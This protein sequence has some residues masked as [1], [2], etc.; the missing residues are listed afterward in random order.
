MEA[1]YG[2]FTKIIFW[3]D[4]YG[5]RST[6][7][8][9]S[10]TK[11]T[12]LNG[13]RWTRARFDAFIKGLLRSGSSRWQPKFDALNEAYVGKKKNKATGRE[14]KHYTCAKCGEDFPS[15]MIEVDHIDPVVDPVVG[16]VDWNTYITRLFSERENYQPLCKPCHKIKSDMEKRVAKERNTNAD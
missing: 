13:G 9:M 16:F 12:N 7:L 2:Q 11:N 8:N 6:L 14:A 5:R 15:S 4:T 10:N 3:S 1:V